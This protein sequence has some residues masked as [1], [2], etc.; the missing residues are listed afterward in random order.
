MNL[1]RDPDIVDA[2]AVGSARRTR[3]R[4]FCT[5]AGR[6][7][8]RIVAVLGVASVLPMH[9]FSPAATADSFVAPRAVAW[10]NGVVRQRFAEDLAVS[11][12]APVLSRS[13]N[14][15]GRGT[16]EI[17]AGL[18]ASSSFLQAQTIVPSTGI[19]V[20]PRPVID[21]NVAAPVA[22]TV[23][24]EL[25]AGRQTAI[26]SHS[27]AAAAKPSDAE[28]I[29]AAGVSHLSAGGPTFA[30][31]VM[32]T[33]AATATMTSS[34]VADP[35]SSSASLVSLRKAAAAAHAGLRA[36]ADAPDTTDLGTAMN[37]PATVWDYVDLPDDT[38]AVVGEA[39]GAA[40]R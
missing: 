14:L 22:R 16:I 36:G 6:D 32:G 27:A 35:S 21:A 4:Q 40:P 28:A 11:P 39:S 2:T 19:A 24:R 12:A 23:S 15:S 33:G 20:A 34:S 7:V 3:L 26:E 13:A 1:A 10:R 8:L 38:T 29:G 9:G 5:A 25:A 30:Q 17:A 18:V 37:S 31:P